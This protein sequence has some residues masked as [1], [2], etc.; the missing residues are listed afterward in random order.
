MF[1][2]KL[3]WL[4]LGLAL[5][6]AAFA[7]DAQTGTAATTSAAAAASASADDDAKSREYFTDLE[8]VTQDGE[9]VRFYSDVLRDQVV[10]INFIFTNCQDACPMMTRMLT[11]VETLLGEDRDKVRFVS[12]SV[13]PERDSPAAMKEFAKK[14]GADHEGWVFLTGDPDRVNFV[15]KRLG[16]YTEEAE[17]HSTLMLAANVKENHWRKVPPMVPPPGI[18]QILRDL[19]ES[20]SVLQ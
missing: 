6:S 16:Q 20:Q 17:A 7:E 1:G 14:H 19:V 3:L 4:T 10:L 9:T 13:D 12:I 2:K 5:G 8:L 11:Q 15:V 18:A